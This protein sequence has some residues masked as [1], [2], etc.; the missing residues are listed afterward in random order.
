MHDNFRFY[1]SMMVY[2]HLPQGDA[3]GYRAMQT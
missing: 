1:S 2:I 3:L